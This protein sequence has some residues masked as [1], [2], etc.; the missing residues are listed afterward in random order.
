MKPYH[1]PISWDGERS[2]FTFAGAPSEFRPKTLSVHSAWVPS[3]LAP[4][5]GGLQGVA[6]GILAGEQR[7]W[8]EKSETCPAGSL[9]SPYYFLRHFPSNLPSQPGPFFLTGCY[10]AV[11]EKAPV[12]PVRGLF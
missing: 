4:F 6:P 2:G 8:W 12:P 11:D 7:L 3:P 10:G 9:V 1:N 5:E